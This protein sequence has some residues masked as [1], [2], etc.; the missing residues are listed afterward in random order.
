MCV[1]VVVF[2][3]M[4]TPSCHHLFFGNAWQVQ[5]IGQ[6]FHWQVV[7]YSPSMAQHRP[8]MAP[9]WPGNRVFIWGLNV[10][11]RW[12][13]RS[14]PNMAQHG[15]NMP[16]HRPNM[17]PTWHGNT[18]FN[19]WGLNLGPRWTRRSWPNTAQHGPNMAQH[20]PNI[21]PTWPRHDPETQCSSR[22]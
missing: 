12:T 22:A 16:E 3:A 10:G 20:R 14:W 15:P 18:V 8:N 19:I 21:G 7:Q 5:E 11:P 17:P 13:R 9:T 4:D 1:C 6:R 2:C